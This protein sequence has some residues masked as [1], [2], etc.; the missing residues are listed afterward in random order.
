MQNAVQ[1]TE[2]LKNLF[3]E[4]KPFLLDI[5]QRD[6]VF[7]TIRAFLKKK[8]LVVICRVEYERLINNQK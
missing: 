8:Q 6:S 4:K 5:R 3:F 2:T 7:D 1:F